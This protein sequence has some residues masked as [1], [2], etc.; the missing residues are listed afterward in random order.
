MRDKS[1]KKKKVTKVG[2]YVGIDQRV[3][4]EFDKALTLDLLYLFVD[5]KKSYWNS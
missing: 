1:S 4:V 5:R 2:R 3:S